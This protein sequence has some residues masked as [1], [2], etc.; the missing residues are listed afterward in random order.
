MEYPWITFSIHGNGE[1]CSELHIGHGERC[2]KY[3]AP[4]TLVN[5]APPRHPYPESEP[6]ARVPFVCDEEIINENNFFRPCSRVKKFVVLGHSFAKEK[7]AY[8]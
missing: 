8:F 3:P 6:A 1:Y 4:A 5:I 7:L 2:S